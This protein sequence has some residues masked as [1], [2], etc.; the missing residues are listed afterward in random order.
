MIGLRND[1]SKNRSPFILHCRVKADSK[2]RR[3]DWTIFKSIKVFIYPIEVEKLSL[4]LQ[5]AAQ[6]AIINTYC[7]DLFQ[8]QCVD[9]TELYF[10]GLDRN[11]GPK[12]YPNE[13][14]E[15]SPPFLRAAQ[16]T[17]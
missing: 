14:E 13:V 7:F 12:Q 17:Q 8:S 6:A 2:S 5:C 16:A 4:S 3:Y 10:Y 15:L 11:N 1:S 9:C